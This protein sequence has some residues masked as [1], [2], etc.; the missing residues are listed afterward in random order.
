MRGRNTEMLS[1]APGFA[2][3]QTN[4]IKRNKH[5]T[6]KSLHKAGMKVSLGVFQIKPPSVN[7]E[8]FYY[9]KI[10]QPAMVKACT[11]NQDKEPQREPDISEPATVP[12]ELRVAPEAS[13]MMGDETIKAQH[14]RE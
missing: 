1:H 9:F 13:G 3:K 5:A 6:H 2:P 14:C 11:C 8:L 7:L 12:S 10:S 4:I